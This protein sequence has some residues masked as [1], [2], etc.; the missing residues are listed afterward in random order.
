MV[1]ASLS[2]GAIKWRYAGRFCDCP[3]PVS[4]TYDG[5]LLLPARCRSMAGLTAIDLSSG[6]A[7]WKGWEPLHT[8]PKED[9]SAYAVRRGAVLFGCGCSSRDVREQGV[10]E[11]GMA[12][13]AMAEG[14]VAASQR[15]QPAGAAQYEQQLSP[16]A[17]SARAAGATVNAAP[18]ATATSHAATTS[19]S[20]S[21][22]GSAGSEGICFYSVELATGRT[23]WARFSEADTSFP[24]DAQVRVAGC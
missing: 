24:E 16:A 20:S 11:P 5:M 6:H 2:S 19:S 22:V 13:G 10:A 8:E 23:N 14:G 18:V 4:S 15:S 9:C 1:A 21:V 3:S 17:A 12:E 7:A